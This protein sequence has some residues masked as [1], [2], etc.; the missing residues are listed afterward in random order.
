MLARETTPVWWSSC[1]SWP[2][3][4][5]HSIYT[6]QHAGLW[7]ANQWSWWRVHGRK[8]LTAHITVDV[9]SSSAPLRMLLGWLEAFITITKQNQQHTGSGEYNALLFEPPASRRPL[10]VENQPWA[11]SLDSPSCPLF[12][13]SLRIGGGGCG[14]KCKLQ[15]VCEP[16]YRQLTFIPSK[17]W[18]SELLTALQSN[19]QHAV[20]G[21]EVS[22]LWNFQKQSQL[23]PLAILNSVTHPQ[24]PTG[25]INLHTNTGPDTFKLCVVH[26]PKSNF[27][28]NLRRLS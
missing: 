23:L 10:D 18:Q 21:F 20:K 24:E 14:V 12:T 25:S 3:E 17:L 4:E 26:T 15:R 28:W 5:V 6:V 27:V 22:Q 8:T 1:L 13:T 19:L 7:W 16:N 2:K 9:S 11:L